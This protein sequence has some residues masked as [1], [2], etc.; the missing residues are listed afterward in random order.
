MSTVDRTLPLLIAGD[1]LSPEEFLRRWEAMPEVKKAA[2]IGGNRLHAIAIEPGT[3]CHGYPRR[4]L[5]GKLRGFHTGLR[6]G[7]KRYL[8]SLACGSMHGHCSRET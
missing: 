1:H 3:R 4:R 2:L 7:G 5:A 6:A 8:A